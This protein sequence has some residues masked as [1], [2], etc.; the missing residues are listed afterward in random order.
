MTSRADWAFVGLG[1]NIGSQAEILARFDDAC[2]RL[3]AG[4]SVDGLVERSPVY[5]SR[6]AG[7]VAEQPDFLNQVAAF[8][9]APGLEPRALLG[10]LLAIEARHGRRRD[11]PQGPR[12][13]DLDLLLF[14]ERVIVEPDLVVPHPRLGFRS[15]VLAPLLDLLA[16][17][18]LQRIHAPSPGG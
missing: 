16:D 4:A 17:P 5:R 1:G 10:L 8:P 13:L 7:P 9:P 18:T 12:T 2:E 3:R 14:G 6:A 11:L 15:F